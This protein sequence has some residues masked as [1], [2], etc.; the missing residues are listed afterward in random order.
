MTKN[1]IVQ[2][3]FEPAGHQPAAI[4][5]LVKGLDDGLLHQVLLGVTVQV[6]HTPWQKSLNL[7]KDQR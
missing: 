4:E 3:P 7:P 2:S 5:S 1:L 6:R